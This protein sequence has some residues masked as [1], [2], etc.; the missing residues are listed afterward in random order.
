MTETQ[1][2]LCPCDDHLDINAM[3]RDAWISRAPSTLG[4]ALIARVTGENCRKLYELP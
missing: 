3:P 2:R 4:E 1:H